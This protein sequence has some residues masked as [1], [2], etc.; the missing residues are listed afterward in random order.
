MTANI[1]PSATAPAQYRSPDSASPG[2]VAVAVLHSIPPA[3]T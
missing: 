2:I 1:M 3:F